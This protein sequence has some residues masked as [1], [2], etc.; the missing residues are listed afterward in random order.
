MNRTAEYQPPRSIRTWLIGR[1]LSTADAPHQAIRKIVGL[2]VFSSDAMSSVAY[3]TQEMFVVLAAAGTM[4]YGISIPISLAIVGLLVILTISYEQTIHAYPGGGGAYIVSRDNLGELP[5][6]TAAAALLTDYILT[7]AVSISAGVAQ[8][9]SAFPMLYPYRVEISVA[10][11]AFVMLINLRGVKESG[12]IFAL[13]TYFFIVMMFFTVIVGIL[14][15]LTGGLGVV[16]DP[17]PTEMLHGAQAVTVFLV[18]RA[19]SSGTTALTG[20]EAISNGIPAFRVPRSRN[21]GLTLIAMSVILGS[22][23]VGITFLSVQIGAVPSEEETVISQLARTIYDGRGILYLATMAAT[24]VILI[25]AA[26]TAFA[27][28]PRLERAGGEGRLPAAATDLPRQPA[29]LLVRHRR[30]GTDRLAADRRL[31]GQ[32]DRPDPALR[33]RRIP[34]VHPFAVGH[35]AALAEKRTSLA[36]PTGGR[37]PARRLCM[38]RSGGPRWSSTRSARCAPPS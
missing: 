9:T 29:G 12:A 32:R 19:F 25:M 11:V 7:V 2:A 28:F 31:P 17:P 22:L 21:A 13:P 14:R 34:L 20:V 30:P 24:T 16:V 38:T 3:A 4:A 33:H 15:Y 36:R 8:I 35:G 6:Q 23:L 27:D 18:L 37:S 10:L 5:A 26:N 1:P